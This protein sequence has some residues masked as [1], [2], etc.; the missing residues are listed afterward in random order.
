MAVK[1]TLG[2]VLAAGAAVRM[3]CNVCAHSSVL[4]TAP[5]AQRHGSAFRLDQMERLGRCTSCGAR[6][7]NC[8]PEYPLAPGVGGMTG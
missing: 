5:L 8:R 4:P 2:G 1:I 3:S 6:E 7:I